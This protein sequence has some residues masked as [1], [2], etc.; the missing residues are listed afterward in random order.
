MFLTPLFAATSLPGAPVGGG[1]SGSLPMLL[2]QFA[3]IGVIFYFLLI[4][5]QQKERKKLQQMLAALKE[6]DKIV[7]TGGIV[8]I[9]TNITD[10]DEIIQI[11][12]SE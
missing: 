12:V 9:I 7:T 1:Q 10:K 5:P 3:I 4:R 6:G 2:V 11:T 8:G